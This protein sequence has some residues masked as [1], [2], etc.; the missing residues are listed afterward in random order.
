MRGGWRLSSVAQR[1]LPR[2]SP[3][4][5]TQTRVAKALNQQAVWHLRGDWP[6]IKEGSEIHNSHGGPQLPGLG[7]QFICQFSHLPTLPPILPPL[8]SANS[9]CL[10][11]LCHAP[12]ERLGLPRGPQHTHSPVGEP[13]MGDRL[14]CI[15]FQVFISELDILQGTGRSLSW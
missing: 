5:L 13:G 6:G 7:L 8:Q 4:R 11:P 15:L 1:A 10:P 2:R 9:L 3:G 14:Q 12:C